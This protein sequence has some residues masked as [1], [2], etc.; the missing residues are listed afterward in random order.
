VNPWQKLDHVAADL[1]GV[2]RTL[3]AILRTRPAPI[4]VPP[5]VIVSS[6]GVRVTPDDLLLVQLR[7]SVAPANVRVRYRLRTLEGKLLEDETNVAATADRAAH[8]F[9]TQL[10]D[11]YLE[12]LAVFATTGGPLRGQLFASAFLASPPAA[13]VIIKRVLG[14][15]YLT[16]QDGV[17][18]PGGRQDAPTEGAGWLHTVTISN[19]AAGA[20][21]TQAVPAGARW[22]VRLVRG[23]FVTSATVASRNPLLRVQPGTVLYT[24]AQGTLTQAAS[25]TESYT[26]SPTTAGEFLNVGAVTRQLPIDLRLPAAGSVLS[27]TANI[28]TT[29]QWSG[30]ELLAEEW[31]E[32]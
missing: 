27:L 9:S 30:L 15:R 14:S 32:A 19:P 10:Y 24:V 1:A 16:G 12:E 3:A 18:F 7:S 4:V 17:T 23:T 5:P 6:S 25:L 22:L 11:G 26:W 28:Q 2:R 8:S 13:N 21:W 31:L 20:D 29:D